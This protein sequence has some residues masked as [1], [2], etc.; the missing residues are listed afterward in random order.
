ML[1]P[2]DVIG[3][4]IRSSVR[5]DAG[6]RPSLIDDHELERV[7]AVDFAHRRLPRMIAM[8]RATRECSTRTR[9]MIYGHCEF[10]Q[11]RVK[12]LPAAGGQGALIPA[13]FG[14]AEQRFPVAS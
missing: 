6:P 10:E 14:I 7:V 11:P 13:A 9:R 1:L 8:P 5:A 3:A 4:N 2:D 12:A